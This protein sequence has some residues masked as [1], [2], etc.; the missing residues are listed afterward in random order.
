M[1]AP[2]NHQSIGAILARATTRLGNRLEAEILLS[3]ALGRSR[4]WLYAH[5]DESCD[6]RQQQS[7]ENLLAKRV[8]GV[9]V[10]YLTEQ[11]AF[12]DYLFRVTPDVLVPRPETELL[13]ET[14]LQADV[15][16]TARV[17]DIGTG[18]GCIAITLALQR[19]DW[20]VLATDVS[21]PALTVARHNRDRLDATVELL[22]GDLFE[23]VSERSFHLIVSNPPYIAAGDAHLDQ[24]E[25]RH[26]PEL[27]LVAGVDGL[28]LIRR[29][30][31]RTP[32]HLEPG[33]WLMLE[34]G[35]D[36]AASVRSLLE[37]SGFNRVGSCRDLA[38]VERVSFGKA[39]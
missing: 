6:A 18:S 26:E 37:S 39:S 31:E 33:G 21:G 14:A 2:Q 32:K 36:Q 38:G 15:P 5:S 7:F 3:W 28:D 12:H 4:A 23:P 11:R 34:H 25:L 22:E 10:A 16:A 29:I 13:I 1:Q 17:L 35:H 27:A 30:V 19:P 24:P 8:N 20:R 9:P